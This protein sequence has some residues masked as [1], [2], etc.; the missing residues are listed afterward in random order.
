MLKRLRENRKSKK[1]FTLVE[2]IVVIVII[3][4]LAAVMVPS[5]LRY[6]EKANQ[7]NCKSDAATI[8]VDIQSQI[9]DK[10]EKAESI[11]TATVLSSNNIT[12]K[13]EKVNA[14]TNETATKRTA[15]GASCGL[16]ADN[17]VVW[18]AY[19][20]DKYETTWSMSAGWVAPAKY[21]ATNNQ[22]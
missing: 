17:E 10:G 7:A 9:A 21:T 22:P 18:F 14:A 12:V 3:L 6:V 20:D 2:L 5:V 19:A 8:L 15:K 4:V 11:T 13:I 1:G 16:S